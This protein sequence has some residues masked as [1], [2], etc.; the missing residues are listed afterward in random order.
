MDRRLV[1]LVGLLLGGVIGG[2]ATYWVEG[3]EASDG[4]WRWATPVPAELDQLQIVEAGWR[5]L[6]D[7]NSAG[8]G[9]STWAWMVRLANP[10]DS[11]WAGRARVTVTLLDPAGLPLAK[12]SRSRQVYHIPPDD[13]LTIF[14]R[15]NTSSQL[16]QEVGRAQVV[17]T[18]YVEC[19]ERISY[20]SL[21]AR[22]GE[23][24]A[25]A[26]REEPDPIGEYL[27]SDLPE[28]SRKYCYGSR[29]DRTRLSVP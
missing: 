3:R 18:S 19:V 21:V 20:D 4:G 24:A 7:S 2:A 25:R 22:V 13:S 14:G 16:L 28:S 12:S 15:S 17:A 6:G 8:Q 1:L 23:E 26:R 10:A 11:S 5:A 9:E 27:D 29:S